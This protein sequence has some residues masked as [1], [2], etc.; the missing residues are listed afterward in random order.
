[1]NYRLRG[2][3]I[4]YVLNDSGAKVVVAGRDHV[5]AVVAASSEVNGDVRYVALGDRVPEG[6]LSYAP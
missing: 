3:E 4:A 6:W 2:P 1:V 5:D